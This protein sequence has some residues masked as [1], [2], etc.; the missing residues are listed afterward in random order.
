MQT[1]RKTR[2]LLGPGQAGKLALLAVLALVASV[3]EAAG[4]LVVFALLTRIMDE[5]ATFEV[6]FFDIMPDGS[7]TSWIVVGC[8][9]VASFFVVRAVVLVSQSYLQSRVT[10]NAAA[11]LA[12]RLVSGYLAMPYSF[13]LQ[14]NSAE[15]IRNTYDTV[16]Q[17]ARDALRPA[18]KLV[19]QSLIVLALGA[20]L[21][22]T[23][24]WA[25]LLAIAVLGS[26]T[27]LLLRVVQPRV[28]RLGVVSQEMSRQNLQ[29]L[30]ESLGGWRDIKVLG[31]ERFFVAQFARDRYGLARVRYVLQTLRDIPRLVLE[32]VLVLFILAFVGVN[33]VVTD[34]AVDALPTL[35]LFGYVAVRL[36]P[37]L[38]E[39]MAALNALK[40]VGPGINLLYEDLRRFPAE[41]PTQ[42][43]P[44]PLT[45][46]QELRLERISIR[47][48]GAQDDA[49]TGVDLTIEAGEFVGVVGP[50]G[51]GKSTL[52]DVILGLLR[53]TTGRVTVDG[54]DIR[55][56][57]KAWHKSLGVVHQTVFLADTTIRRNVALGVPDEEIDDALVSEAIQLAQLE[58]F[59]ASLPHGVESLVGQRGVRLSGGQRQRLAIARALYRQPSILVFDE[60]TAALDTVTE[61]ELMAALVPLRGERTIIAVAHRLTTVA[62]ADR[63]ILVDGGR[64]V[65]VAPFDELAA[66]HAQLRV[67]AH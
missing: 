27:W 48:E 34:G 36:Q 14:R 26:F 21:L 17:Y 51:G 1:L 12:T 10:E 57:E 44:T 59:A 50:T 9:T 62:A 42:V 61:R 4:A 41:A 40:F 8:I 54:V 63:V 13:L 55:G 29:T 7:D 2:A 38:N 56:N 28:K 39:I 23:S 49:L 3:V 20:V 53:P 15:L 18:I 52:V 5:Q 11:D 35:A 31:R 67:T 19:S 43:D 22:A 45:L 65:D 46:Q 37:S 58:K 64:L 32:T 60:G 30:D 66:R 24:P 47:Y 33:A 16:Q 6:P 25:T